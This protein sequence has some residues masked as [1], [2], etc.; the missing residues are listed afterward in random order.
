ME[1]KLCSKCLLTKKMENFSKQGKN[2]WCRDCSNEYAK[3]YREKNKASIKTKA[4]Q[5]YEKNKDKK[6][7]YDKSRLAYVRE[8]DRQRYATDMNFRL[9]KVLRTRLLKTIKGIKTS[10]SMLSYL[11]V[12][13]QFFKSFLQYQFNDEMTW[14]N[15]G[16]VWEI[17]H[18]IPCSYFD[19]TIE[20][21]KKECFTWSNMRPLLKQDNSSKSDTY[22]ENIITEHKKVVDEYL[23]SIQYQVSIKSVDGVE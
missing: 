4:N 2:P 20:E 8:R 19:L 15:Y 9:K 14:D 22:D 7:E 5:Y 10:R 6:Q 11:G 3:E 1:D 12:T 18:V 16:N 23:M 17:D 21:A 13:L